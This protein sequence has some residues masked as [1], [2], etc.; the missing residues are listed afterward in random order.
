MHQ[1]SADCTAVIKCIGEVYF[2]SGNIIRMPLE[3]RL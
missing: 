2:A 1:L 3:V